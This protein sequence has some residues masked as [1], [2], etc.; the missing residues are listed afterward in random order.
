MNE[1]FYNVPDNVIE[2]VKKYFAEQLPNYEVSKV[3]R[4]STHPD[5]W[6]LFMVI[7]RKKEDPY[8]MGRYTCWTCWNET[9]QSLNFGHYG[10]D[11]EAKALEI[12]SEFFNY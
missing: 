2:N 11:T 3:V 1:I 7:G 8:S 6:Y 4:K 5:D 10:I 9:M 12:L